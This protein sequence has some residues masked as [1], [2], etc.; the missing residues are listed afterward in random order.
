MKPPTTP[1]AVESL[2]L[3][4]ETLRLM[5]GHLKIQDDDALQLESVRAQIKRYANQG[6]HKW[7]AIES[8]VR[9]HTGLARLI[10]FRG[11]MTSG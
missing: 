6:S 11:G 10:E 5:G 1:E 8:F 4:S 9:Q 2:R 3:M 7:R